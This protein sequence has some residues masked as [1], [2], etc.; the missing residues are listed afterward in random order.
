MPSETRQKAESWQRMPMLESEAQ[1]A[2]LKPAT[3]GVQPAGMVVD[4]LILTP[5]RKISSSPA[6]PGGTPTVSP[7]SAPPL[8]LGL[9]VRAVTT[10]WKAGAWAAAAGAIARPAR[11]AA[12][13]RTTE[14]GHRGGHHT[15]FWS[16]GVGALHP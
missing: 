2:S 16:A 6:G 3:I 1:M 13:T 11:S 5:T 14:A 10:L 12:A 15:S 4:G 9:V 8:K 7:K